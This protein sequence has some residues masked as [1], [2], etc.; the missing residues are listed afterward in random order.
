MARAFLARSE[1][2]RTLMPAV[3]VRIAGRREYALA[4]D[5]HHAG[6]A[7]PVWPVARLGSMA[8]MRDV[9]AQ[10]LRHSP[11]R[12]AGQGF[13]APAVEFEGVAGAI[14]AAART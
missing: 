2:E 6:A 1:A 9:G 4:L 14:A 13:D 7:I 8:E 3:G 5:L 11:D 12:L 10:P